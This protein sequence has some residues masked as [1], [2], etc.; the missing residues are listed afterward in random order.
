M[1]S[2]DL[3]GA[4]KLG[5]LVCLF[6][7]PLASSAA[8]SD[9][10]PSNPEDVV[11]K[12]LTLDAEGAWFT[13]EGQAELQK[14]TKDIIYV[15]T[16]IAPYVITGYRVVASTLTDDE[17]IVEVE[18]HVI[19]YSENL[20]TFDP[21]N[22]QVRK[23]IRLKRFEGRWIILTQ[24]FPHMSWQAVINQLRNA[25]KNSAG[26]LANISDERKRQKYERQIKQE[27]AHRD[28]L[29]QQITRAANAADF[30][31]K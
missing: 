20:A 26:F 14:Y 6:I 12:Y 21:R 29:V 5:L 19:G 30:N 27:N 2:S 1:K 17:A 24:I 22:E 25:Q 8:Q 9:I 7:S 28:S 11:K 18:Y 4:I 13:K 3:L 31:S 15:A 10:Y 16:I 23:K